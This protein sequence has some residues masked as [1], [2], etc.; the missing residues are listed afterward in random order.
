[1]TAPEFIAWAQEQPHGRYELVDGEVEVQMAGGDA[2]RHNLTK[3]EV[4]TALRDAVAA[5]GAVCTVFTDGMMVPIA[6]KRVRVPDALV[7]AGRLPDIDDTSVPNPLILV[8]VVS[9]DSMVRDSVLKVADYFSLASV[10]H[11]L[12]VNPFD[13]MVLHYR[14]SGDDF[15]T[16]IL[17]SGDV[18]LD[19]PGITLSVDRILAAGAG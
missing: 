19:P 6:P 17:R 4:Y 18:Q 9:P 14:R 11:Y 16:R 5:A 1:M 12:I 13:P 8:E 2:G 3:G 15:I 10:Q 7:M